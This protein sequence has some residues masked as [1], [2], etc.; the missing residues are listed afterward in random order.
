MVHGPESLAGDLAANNHPWLAAAAVHPFLTLGAVAGAAYFGPR[1][2]R[3]I[4]NE[5]GDARQRFT[6]GLLGR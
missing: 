1:V 6:D 4:G 2:V 5:I 3:R